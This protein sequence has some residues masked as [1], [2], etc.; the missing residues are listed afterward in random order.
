M[1]TD[2]DLP[3]LSDTLQQQ[4]PRSFKPLKPHA[5]L[6]AGL[7]IALVAGVGGY[8]LG[9]RANQNAPQSAPKVSFRPSPTG[10]AQTSMFAPSPRTQALTV[11]LDI[12]SKVHAG[13]TV[14]LTLIVKDFSDNVAEISLESLVG[15][16]ARHGF[17]VTRQDDTEVLPALSV[18][19]VR[20]L[21]RAV[22]PL[23]HL[24]EEQATERII[25]HLLNRTRSR[26]SRIKKQ[27]LMK[28]AEF[29]L[30]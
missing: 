2:N 29:G 20:E 12:P 14:P 1:S 3:H 8:L 17:I 4:P 19:N 27:R 6:A 22:M 21:L 26:K 24:T 25:E 28:N 13:T 23:K 11:W 18:A 7:L 5:L 30:T 16:P 15:R 10:A 9:I